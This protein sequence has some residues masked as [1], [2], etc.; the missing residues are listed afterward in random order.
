MSAG[1]RD[2]PEINLFLGAERGLGG[3]GSA[4]WWWW[5]QNRFPTFRDGSKELGVWA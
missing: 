5:L 4:G 2:L 3:N 1:L